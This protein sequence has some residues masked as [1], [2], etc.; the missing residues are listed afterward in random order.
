MT[1]NDRQEPEYIRQS[2]D[3]MTDDEARDWYAEAASEAR[4]AGITHAR[5]SYHPDIPNLRIVE[6]WRV[7]P[8]DEGDIRWALTDKLAGI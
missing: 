7:R 8:A 3:V 1:G 2:G 6:G 5:F 4:A